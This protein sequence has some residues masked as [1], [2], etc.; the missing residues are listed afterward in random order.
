MA[1]PHMFEFGV[2]PAFN[3]GL[4]CVLHMRKTQR[5]NAG[6]VSSD[7]RP[8]RASS[9]PLTLRT[10]ARSAGSSER[11][12]HRARACLQSSDDLLEHF[13]EK[14]LPVFP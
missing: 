11:S 3:C 2:E 1:L 13:P 6:N 10:S 14:W 9:L 7:A 5:Q 4:A 12:L 8:P